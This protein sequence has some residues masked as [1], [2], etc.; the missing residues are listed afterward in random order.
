MAD[1]TESKNQV[2]AG[3]RYAGAS[4]GTL[5]TVLGALQFVTP[6]QVAELT[7]QIHILNDSLFT[8][9]GALLKMWVILGPVMVGVLGYFGVK[10]SSVKAIGE[11]LRAIATGAASP[12][13]REAQKVAIQVTGAIAQ[14]KSI[15]ASTEA[16]VA[17]LDAVTENVGVIGKINV[18]DQKLVDRTVS[19][20]VQKAA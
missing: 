1:L 13:S 15:P 3:L 5:F 20:Q 9:Y 12:A 6:E 11:K 14:D 10:S 19:D 17:L 8:A 2:N 16:K 7:T 18:T 4:A